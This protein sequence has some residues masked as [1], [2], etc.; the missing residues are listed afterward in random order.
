MM[1]QRLVSSRGPVA[2]SRRL[3][4]ARRNMDS[5]ADRPLGLAEPPKR[6]AEPAVEC[7]RNARKSPGFKSP[8]AR[9][10]T[11]ASPENRP[12]SGFYI[13]QR[14]GSRP[15]TAAHKALLK[16][17][18]VRRWYDN[19]SRASVTMWPRVVAIARFVDLADVPS[20]DGWLDGFGE[21]AE[22]LRLYENL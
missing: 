22:R 11:W 3:T 14:G 17:P 2:Q 18:Q 8:R 9:Q 19:V 6:T 4:P 5:A 21:L 12:G 20:D 16:D 1:A 15:H 10:T 13:N 7:V